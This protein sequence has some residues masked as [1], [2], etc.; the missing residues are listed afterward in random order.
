[1][2]I[3]ESSPASYSSEIHAQTGGNKPH[4]KGGNKATKKNVGG[5]KSVKGG[6]MLGEIAVP[7]LFVAANTLVKKGKRKTN[8][9][10]MSKRRFSSKRR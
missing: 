10:R 7:A 3:F 5:K 4:K 8:K 1:M 6:N 2:S 9:R